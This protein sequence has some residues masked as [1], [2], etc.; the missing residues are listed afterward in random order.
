LTLDIIEK[1]AIFSEIA[2][3][4]FSGR[5]FTRCPIFCISISKIGY[6]LFVGV[7]FVLFWYPVIKEMSRTKKFILP[8][9]CAVM[10]WPLLMLYPAFSRKK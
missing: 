10:V 7:Y 4:Y 8:A 3:T 9:I 6:Y 1:D 2:E 5:G